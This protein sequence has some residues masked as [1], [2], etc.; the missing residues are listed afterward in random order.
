MFVSSEIIGIS[1][2]SWSS[3]GEEINEPYK[4]FNLSALVISVETPLA[5]SKVTLLLPIPIAS[6]KTNLL[7]SKTDID[8]VECPRSIHIVPSSFSSCVNED[9]DEDNGDGI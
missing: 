5:I 2:I 8:E 7:F 4:V 9:I 6:A 1:I 3:L